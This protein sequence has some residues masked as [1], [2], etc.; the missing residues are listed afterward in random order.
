MQTHPIT[1][2]TLV[3]APLNLVWRMWITPQD[4]MGWNNASD[5]WYTPSAQN[6]LR[7]GGM[8]HYTMASRDG[9]H[10]FDFSGVYTEIIP[11]KSIAYTL[12]DGRN[13][14]VTFAVQGNA[15]NVTETFDPEQEN[16]TALQ[17]AGWQ[18][19][20]DH[21]KRYVENSVVA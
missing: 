7:V 1:V 2:E 11:E 5:D 6:D 21:F 8:F 14:Y 10:S 4:V 16:S 18:S 17:R 19:I 9:N 20:L 15:I 13:V 3:N 12:E